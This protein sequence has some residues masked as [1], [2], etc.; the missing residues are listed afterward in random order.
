MAH[1]DALSRI[2]ASI[3]LLPLERELEF[4]QLKDSFIKEIAMDLETSEDNKAKEKFEIIDGLVFKKGPDKSRFYIPDSMVNNIIR[5]YHD[6]M[7]HCGSE[8]TVQGI[9]EN[10]WFPS[11]RKRVNLYIE[12]C[13]T[14]L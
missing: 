5:V 8:K 13:I 11:L 6:N 1:V 3:S 12:N 2:V 4:R 14:C 9:L 10:Y 7:A